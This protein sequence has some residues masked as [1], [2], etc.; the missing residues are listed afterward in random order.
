MYKDE[1]KRVYKGYKAKKL[2]V[3]AL[4][5]DL[6]AQKKYS[7]SLATQLTESKKK[8]EHLKCKRQKRQ[9]SATRSL[10]NSLKELKEVHG[11]VKFQLKQKKV[12]LQEAEEA[13][14]WQTLVAQKALKERE[15][16]QASEKQ[17]LIYAET[18]ENEVVKIIGTVLKR[19]N[20]VSTMK[21]DPWKEYR[22]EIAASLGRLR[23]FAAAA[24]I[25]IKQ[26]QEAYLAPTLALLEHEEPPEANGVRSKKFIRDDESSSPSCEP[27]EASAGDSVSSLT[28]HVPL[29]DDANQYEE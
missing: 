17:A 25:D 12:Q 13:L 22:P 7:Q 11:D 15:E 28:T 1:Y 21:D 16:F 8:V 18:L 29:F 19:T 14:A 6:A 2:L 24:A 20:E 9:N 10:C 26:K 5:I 27:T 23:A 3:E 4:K